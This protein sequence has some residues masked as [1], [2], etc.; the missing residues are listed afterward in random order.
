MDQRLAL[1][2]VA[3]PDRLPALIVEVKTRRQD[4]DQLLPVVSDR[5]GFFQLA[6]HC[7]AYPYPGQG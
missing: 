5:H 2:L 6:C 1:R 3:F 4:A 7:G